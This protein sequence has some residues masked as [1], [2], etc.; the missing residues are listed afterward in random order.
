[1]TR[2]DQQLQFILEIDKLK[3][4]YRRS[5]LIDLSRTENSAEHSWHVAILAMLLAEYSDN[6]LES[7]RVI[8]M[9]LL[10][11]IVEIDA[12]DTFLYDEQATQQKAELEE[13]AAQRLFGL[14]PQDQATEF[15]DLWREFEERKTP[16]ARFARGLDRLMPL[17]HNYYTKGATWREHGVRREQVLAQ[18]SIIGDASAELWR[19]AQKLINDAVDLGYL[20]P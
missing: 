14:L 8:K 3:H 2:F 15:R 4:V 9:M 16:E 1:M 13:K 20:L 12:G 17:L 19:F 18:N 11:D 5:F 7:S 10:H 6:R